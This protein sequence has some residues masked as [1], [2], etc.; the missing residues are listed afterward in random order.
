MTNASKFK[1]EREIKDIQTYLERA[2]RDILL[3]DRNFIE[4]KRMRLKELEREYKE[5][6]Q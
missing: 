6:S 2:E 1:I 5:L 4:G 3:F